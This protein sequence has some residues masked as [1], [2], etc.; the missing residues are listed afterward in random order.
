[1]VQG[2][3]PGALQGCWGQIHSRG[4]GSVEQLP[5]EVPRSSWG[6]RWRSGKMD[7]GLTR[8]TAGITFFSYRGS[9]CHPAPRMGRVGGLLGSRAGTATSCHTGKPLRLHR[10]PWKQAHHSN[11]LLSLGLLPA[12][13]PPQEKGAARGSLAPRPGHAK[14]RQSR[15]GLCFLA[16]AL[17]S[18]HGAARHH[19]RLPGHQ[20]QLFPGWSQETTIH[21]EGKSQHSLTLPPHL[22]LPD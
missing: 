12:R 19:P 7:L 21:R 16:A 14:S 10:C 20:D 1:M 11:P 18:P 2:L 8:D 15:P 13:P 5:A 17:C 4:H 22:A 3:Q 9:L 6:S